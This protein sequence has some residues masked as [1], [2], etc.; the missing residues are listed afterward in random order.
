M[1]RAEYVDGGEM[2]YSKFNS[3]GDYHTLKDE[4]GQWQISS[5]LIR[6]K[7]W[8]ESRDAEYNYNPFSCPLCERY[9]DC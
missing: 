1:L 8:L 3:R 2:E 4:R 6:S 9:C 5:C 7:L